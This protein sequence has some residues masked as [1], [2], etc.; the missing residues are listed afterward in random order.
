[1]KELSIKEARN[2]LASAKRTKGQFFGVHFTSRETGEKKVINGK[3]GVRQGIT[4]KG[5]RYLD[6][7]QGLVTVWARN[8][9]GYRS[10]PLERIDR[11]TMDGEEYRVVPA[12][13]TILA[14]LGINPLF[15]WEIN[16]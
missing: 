5:K 1:M 7:L 4:G 10:I 6:I 2:L 11:I 13:Q 3:A 15:E 9:D 14:G 12:K 16:Y 8:R